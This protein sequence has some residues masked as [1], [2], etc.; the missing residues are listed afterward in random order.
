MSFSL[1][2]FRPTSQTGSDQSFVPRFKA[3]LALSLGIL[4][5]VA[6][7]GSVVQARSAQSRITETFRN[8]P[9]PLL[10]H[11]QEQTHDHKQPTNVD[12]FIIEMVDGVSTC[13]EATLAEIPSTL[14]RPGDKGLPVN[15]LLKPSE[16][17]AAITSGDN[18]ADGLTI[19]LLALS[20]LQTDSQKDLVI[21]AFQRAAAVWTSRIKTPITIAMNI[22]YGVNRAN[23]QPF[24]SS[25]VLGSTSSG[26]LGSDYPTIRARLIAGAS[27]AAEANIYNAL[28]V[29]SIPTDTA[30]G[31]VIEVSRSLTQTLGLVGPDPDTVV[32]TISFN[33]NFSFDFNPDDGIES[34]TTD[35]VA[36]ATHEIGHA[37]G[38]TSS[39]GEGS[40]APMTLWDMYR[41][42]PGTTAGTF[43]TAQRIMTIGGTQVYFTGQTFVVNGANT[44]ELGL[45]TGGPAPG[46]GDGDGRQSSHWK[47]DEL[48]G[49]YIG[50][51]DPTISS[52]TLKLPTENDFMALETIGWNLVAS[53]APPPPPP[54]PANDNFANAQVITG[55]TGTV[56]GS[57]LHS[58]KEAGEPTHVTGGGSRSVW[59]QWQAPSNGVA[60]VT[61][62]GSGYDTILAVYTGTS[63]NALGS[64][65]ASND[66]IPD[67]PGQPHEVTSSITFMA[68]AGTIYRIVVDGF[69]NGGSGGDMGPITLNW[70]QANCSQPSGIQLGV[71]VASV[72]ESAGTAQLT[73]TRGDTAGAATVDYATSDTAGLNE[74]TV[75]NGVASSRCDY[76]TS[77]GIVR[78]AA[79]EGSKTIFIPVVNDSY[80]EGSETFTLT[81]SNPTGGTLGTP[82][83]AQITI[84]DNETVNGANPIDDN[85]F[86]IRQQ[87]IDFLGR[88]PDPGGLA[89]WRNVL[90][91][92]GITIAPPCDRIE[93]S[94]GFFRSEEF[95]S[96]GYFIYR[97][98]S[99]VGRIPVSEDFYPDF[100]KVSGF[101]TADQLEANKAAYVN[102]VMARPD[103]QT[104]YGST[105]TNPTAYV[106]ALLNTVGLPS[107]PSK[108]TWIN[109]LTASNTTTTRGQ[110]LRQLVESAEV[111]NKYF[112]EAFVIMQYFG[113]L[114]RTADAS[115]LNWIQTMNQTGGDYRIMI[116]GFMNSAEYRRRFGP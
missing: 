42:R 116:N 46:A 22:E 93:V 107:H 114:R 101:L 63:V 12:G 35:F 38:F 98:F 47:A 49:Q 8:S 45:S 10:P 86:F 109:N 4:V 82:S 105:L 89:G 96:R 60:T 99:A 3:S 33:K 81:L 103:F 62:E 50:I 83:S 68:S 25:S 2:G 24:N 40:S 108:Q 17:D 73:V 41:F 29:T 70:E 31:S 69:N 44:T 6:P 75:L 112:N 65:L 9:A 94:A 92:C 64:A 113:Y 34:G 74:C 111:F 32:A 37:I 77:R 59:Y 39:A 66:D 91:N 55:C 15:S 85:D 21:A 58:T 43:Q 71:T 76:A 48:T 84:Q 104:R 110:V 19:N 18:A 5:F 30:S 23:G 52:G 36:V 20:Q 7:L 11:S 54:P 102:E 56:A 1:S 80:A 14:P 90:V 28:P 106:E 79:G 97:F 78:F 95:Q 26:S 61:T 51:M 16:R 27:S 88:E 72:N 115:Y 100:A 57:N 53:T 13:R 67:V 87:Y